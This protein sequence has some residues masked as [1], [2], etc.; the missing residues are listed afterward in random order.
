MLLERGE[1]LGLLQ[2][3]D[4]LLVRQVKVQRLVERRAGGDVVDAAGAKEAKRAASAV[5]ATATLGGLVAY[6]VRTDKDDKEVLVVMEEK[7]GDQPS[8]NDARGAARS[9]QRAHRSALTGPVRENP[10]VSVRDRVSHSHRHTD[11]SLSLIS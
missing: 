6:S 4:H 8:R 9:G 11:H 2:L 5:E 10:S 7:D 3:L 1:E